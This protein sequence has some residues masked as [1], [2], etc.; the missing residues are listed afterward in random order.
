M[1]LSAAEYRH[2]IDL[3][4]H[5][6]PET[7]RLGYTLLQNHP[8][9][10]RQAAPAL[11]VVAQ[12]GTDYDLC[13]EL[14]DHLYQQQY[15]PYL[16]WKSGFELFFVPYE[17]IQELRE[18]MPQLLEQHE[19]VRELIAP[20]ILQNAHYSEYYF[21]VAYLL[22]SQLN[23]HYE[24]ASRFYR[25]AIQGRPDDPR[26]YLNLGTLYRDQ[27]KDYE[28]SAAC[29]RSLT[30]RY[31]QNDHAYY[32]LGMVCVDY[33]KNCPE[34]AIQ[35]LECS[36]ELMPYNGDAHFLLAKAHL[37]KG[38]QAAYV[39]LLEQGLHDFPHNKKGMLMAAAYHWREGRDSNRAEEL[40]RQLLEGYPDEALALGQLADLLVEE[41]Q[42]YRQA[43]EYYSRAL[44]L[45]HN[46]QYLLPCINLLVFHLDDMDTAAY[47]YTRWLSLS[48]EEQQSACFSDQQLA[49]FVQA[50]QRLHQY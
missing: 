8:K 5:E 34:E 7:A 11:M 44:E 41:R 38:D 2:A 32:L 18:L 27:I 28:A 17:S 16:Q 26:S 24:Q 1:A 43:Q 30:E 15:L 35:A 47:Y 40:Y 4:L 22:Q 14:V 39:Q 23:D 37:Q 33:L 12:L 31:P 13:A 48:K 42:D 29:F 19:Q 49:D 21:Q 10:L 9:D 50:E 45:Y 46:P 20:F 25:Y 6:A 3:L 36:L